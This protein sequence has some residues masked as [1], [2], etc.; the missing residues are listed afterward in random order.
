MQQ[1]V[2]PNLLT[3]AEKKEP[4]D[5]PTQLFRSGVSAEDILKRFVVDHWK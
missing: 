5:I 4:E 1:N 3:E 2:S